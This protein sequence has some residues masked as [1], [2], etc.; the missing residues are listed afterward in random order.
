MGIGGRSGV[1]IA[2]TTG[3]IAGHAS[4]RLVTRVSTGI[5]KAGGQIYSVTQQIPVVAQIMRFIRNQINEYVSTINTATHTKDFLGEFGDAIVKGT[6]EGVESFQSAANHLRSLKG[7]R[8]VDPILSFTKDEVIDDMAKVLEKAVKNKKVDLILDGA[9]TAEDVGQTMGKEILNSVSRMQAVEKALGSNVASASYAR[10][11]KVG[12]A[13]SETAGAAQKSGAATINN[14]PFILLLSEAPS[15]SAF[16][17]RPFIIPVG[18]S[19]LGKKSASTSQLLDGGGGERGFIN[20]GAEFAD[21][22][23]KFASK[24][25]DDILV[26]LSDDSVKMTKY[27]KKTGEIS[28]ASS[29]KSLIFLSVDSNLNVLHRP[30]LF[31]KTNTRLDDILVDSIPDVVVN[32]KNVPKSLN[33][34][35]AKNKNQPYGAAS[36]TAAVNYFI[37]PGSN[38]L[39]ATSTVSVAETGVQLGTKTKIGIG[40]S[41]TALVTGSIAG[42]VIDKLEKD[43]KFKVLTEMLS[44]KNFTK[45]EI[46]DYMEENGISPKLIDLQEVP[47]IPLDK[48]QMVVMKNLIESLIVVKNIKNETDL[49][50]ELESE[51][52]T[53]K[54]YESFKAA[55]IAEFEKVQEENR[56][57]EGEYY[58]ANNMTITDIIDNTKEVITTAFDEYNITSFYRTLPIQEI[59]LETG[60]KMVIAG[61]PDVISHEWFIVEGEEVWKIDTSKMIGNIYITNQLKET[62]ETNGTNAHVFIYTAD[63]VHNERLKRLMLVDVIRYK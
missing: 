18:V 3:E 61:Y 35:K 17:V 55:A 15:S 24:S 36:S 14:N 2:R 34:G 63:I 25:A 48:V 57:K 1:E 40:I 11:A 27:A 5:A 42:I 43:R 50:K 45:E 8:T 19:K 51:N 39:S 16:K 56:K 53:R 9:E 28:S 58:K 33:A 47:E 44:A 41:A 10:A 7:D 22:G 46:L 20:H 49:I 13:V 31:R 12:G 60:D 30:F 59:F 23:I 37:R 62:N 38:S 6:D 32:P 52:V 21:D 4:P 54:E 29:D 26:D